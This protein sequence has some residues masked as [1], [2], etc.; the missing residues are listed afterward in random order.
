MCKPSSERTT[1][2]LRPWLDDYLC[3]YLHSI[4]LHIVSDMIYF[5]CC[6][7][8]GRGPRFEA[9]TRKPVRAI[10]PCQWGACQASYHNRLEHIH[11]RA[12]VFYHEAGQMVGGSSP[13]TTI[14]GVIDAISEQIWAR[15]CWSESKN[16]QGFS[17]TLQPNFISL[18]HLHLASLVQSQQ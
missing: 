14:L 4:T 7:G 17:R 10:C 15:K 6:R 1:N 2:L 8:K 18:P 5:S 13:L 11:L 3:V 12:V 16:I 9:W